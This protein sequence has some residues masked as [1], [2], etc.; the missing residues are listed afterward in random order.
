MPA[1]YRRRRERHVTV[2][3][4]IV[5]KIIEEFKP[6][7]VV[8]GHLHEFFGTSGIIDMGERK[9]L[10]INPGPRGATVKIDSA[11]GTVTHE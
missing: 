4:R 11:L 3:W 10:I 7:L 2:S 9:S 1:L 6:V 5:I 8:Q